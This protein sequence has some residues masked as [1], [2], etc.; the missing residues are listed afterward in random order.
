MLTNFLVSGS[1]TASNQSLG[2]D[3]R[4][5]RSNCDNDAVWQALTIPPADVTPDPQ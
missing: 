1:L 4:P 2:L 5:H 3:F